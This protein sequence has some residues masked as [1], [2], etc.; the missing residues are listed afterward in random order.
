M[1]YTSKFRCFEPLEN[2]LPMAG[3]VSVALEGSLLNV[4]G[5]NLANEVT[6]TQ[7]AVGT[8]VVRGLNNT[9]INGLPQV[10]LPN[11]ALNALDVR[12]EGGNDRVTITNLRAANDVNIDLGAGNDTA[13]VAGSTIGANFSALGS[14]GVDNVTL[15]GGSIGGDAFIDLGLDRGVASISSLNIGFNLDVITDLAND[16]VTLNGV[17]AGGAVTLDSK[18]GADSISITGLNAFLLGI[19]TDS[20]A[21]TVTLQNVRTVTDLEINTGTGGDTVRLTDVISGKSIKVNTDADNDSV[22][23]TRVSAAEDAVFEGGAGFDTL[24]GLTQI[25][26]GVKKEIKEFEFSL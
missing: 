3:N 26:G 13:R 14:Q 23:A 25:S 17:T 7:N 24:F 5:D 21:D 1:K 12:L 16:Q 20:G 11:V 22:N 6:I 8:I 18:A 10:T 4:F 9:R 2:R 15:T 19:Q